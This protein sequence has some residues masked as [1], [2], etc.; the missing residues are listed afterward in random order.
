MMNSFAQGLFKRVEW[1]IALKTAL[2]AG[3]SLA[4]S[5][6]INTYFKRPDTIISGLWAALAAIVVQQAHLGSTYRTAWQRLLGVLIGCLMGGLLT[7]LLGSNPLSLG[8]GIFLTVVICSMFNLKESLRIACLSVAVVMILWGIRPQ[9]SPWLFGMYRFFDSCLGVAVAV[10]IAHLVW[11]LQVTKKL[12]S[13]VSEILQKIRSMYELGDENG[14]RGLEMSILK[15]NEEMMRFRQA[16]LTR[17]YSLDDVEGYFV[18]FYNA[19]AISEEFLRTRK[20]LDAIVTQ[21]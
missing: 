7:T 10:M 17:E 9:T 21:E 4:L 11:P 1:K 12:E 5:L 20:H 3:I 2:A 16:R 19:R 14:V 18:Y 8:I 13:G 6:A 15:M